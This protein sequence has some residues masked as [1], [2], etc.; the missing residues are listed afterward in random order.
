MEKPEKNEHVNLIEELDN[1][2]DVEKIK[3]IKE[4]LSVL[5]YIKNPSE[6]VQLAAINET[7]SAFEYIEN[8]TNSVMDIILNEEPNLFYDSLSKSI[9]INEDYLIKLLRKLEVCGIRYYYD[10]NEFIEYE[11]VVKEPTEELCIKVISDENFVVKGK[12]DDL[13]EQMKIE[14]V[15]KLS[16]CIKYIENPSEKIQLA[17]VR[18][19]GFSLKY[20]SNPSNFIKEEAKKQ[21]DSLVF[22][23]VDSL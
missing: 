2:S 7:L 18:K 13:S 23:D 4:D 11:E 3:L 9:K 8:P 5:D 1:L 19:N 17:A 21:I 14:A 15:T 20:I 22:P 10:N 16:S 12:I 6:I